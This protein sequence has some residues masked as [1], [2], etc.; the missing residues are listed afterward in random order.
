MRLRQE[1]QLISPTTSAQDEPRDPAPKTVDKEAETVQA[2]TA[3]E[4]AFHCTSKQ[5]GQERVTKGLQ[6]WK[7][8]VRAQAVAEQPATKA[9][10]QGMG[11]KEHQGGLGLEAEGQGVQRLGSGHPWLPDHSLQCRIWSG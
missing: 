8:T 11:A 3:G 9:R 6:Q 1:E 4:A 10:D 2:D 5:P 7:Q